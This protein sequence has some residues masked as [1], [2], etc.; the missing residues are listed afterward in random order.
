[1]TLAGKA[2]QYSDKHITFSVETQDNYED[3]H[4]LGSEEIQ[5]FHNPNYLYLK[6]EYLE[7]VNDVLSNNIDIELHVNFKKSDSLLNSYYIQLKNK[8][9]S[10][11]SIN[12]FG[13]VYTPKIS[14][15]K[16]RNKQL[17]WIKYKEASANFFQLT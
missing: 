17:N 6:D 7:L 10:N 11:G 9:D 8:A 1:M 4:V 2:F 14:F 12:V 15:T 3:N 5:G 16:L 13:D